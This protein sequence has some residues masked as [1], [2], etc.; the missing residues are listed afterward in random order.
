MDKIKNLYDKLKA[1]S[2]EH[3][4]KYYDE[5]KEEERQLLLNQLSRIDFDLLRQCNILLKKSDGSG[6]YIPGTLEPMKVVTLPKT[7]SEKK[8]YEKAFNIGEKLISEGKVGSILVAGGQ[9][10]RLGFDGPKG[11]F[12]VGPITDRSLFQYHTEKILAREKKLNAAIPFY[13]MTSE[14]N[15]LQTKDFFKQHRYFKKEKDSFVFFAQGMLPA[16]SAEGKMYLSDKFKISVAP[17]GHGGLLRA[18]FVNRLLDDMQK[19]G[20]EYLY[21]FQVDSP[22]A[23]VCDPAFIGYH[24]LK[25]AEMSAKTVYKRGPYE[26]LGN[27]GKVNGKNVVIEYSELTRKEMEERNP[28]GRLRFG[29]GSIGIHVFSVNFFRRLHDKKQ[30]LP[31]HIAHKRIPYIDAAGNLVQPVEP[32]GYK[33]EQFIFDAFPFAKKIMV[34]ETDRKKDFS[35]IKNK[36]GFD[37]PQTARQD[38]CNQFGN[39][40]GKAGFHVKRDSNGNVLDKIEISPLFA[41]D[42]KEFHNRKPK[43]NGNKDGYLFE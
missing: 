14:L 42:E 43:P 15:Y 23:N 37:S 8:E 19:R 25:N 22:L 41:L 16:L 30:D 26:S 33:F 34:F 12:P 20:V 7:E 17:D 10:T 24:V 18:L 40:L 28:D 3:V 35:P 11:T 2:Q 36:D 21:Y 31:Y 13:I 5:L 39:W 29:Q 27:I 4:L 1:I 32:N 38:L 9:G 6:H